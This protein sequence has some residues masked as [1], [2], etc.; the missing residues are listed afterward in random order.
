MVDFPQLLARFAAAVERNDGAAL[1][2]LFSADGVYEDGFF[3]A[4]RGPAAIAGMLDHFHETGTRFRWEFYAP[5]CDGGT[6]YARY[7]FSYASRMAGADGRPVVFEGIAHFVL[8]DA[9]IA[10][11]SE[12]FDRGLALVQQGFVA[13]RIKRVLEKA[14]ARQ[15]D[16]P[17]C[18]AHLARLAGI[19]Q[20]NE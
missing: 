10:R 9:R 18:R 15:N 2:A 20:P 11:Y 1:A 7:R 17:D 19:A 8:Q 16:T 12:I 13:E 5:L 14:A 6:G 3:G 4:Y